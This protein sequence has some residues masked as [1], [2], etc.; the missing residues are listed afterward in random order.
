MISGFE[1]MHL[2]ITE[3]SNYEP[4]CQRSIR[5]SEKCDEVGFSIIKIAYKFFSAVKMSMA[6][7]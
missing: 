7:I 5:N 4:H 6:V 1:I 3:Q 2:Y